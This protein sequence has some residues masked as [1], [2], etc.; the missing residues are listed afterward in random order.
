MSA[1]DNPELIGGQRQLQLQG[2]GPGA[3]YNVA[4]TRP[5]RLVETA[6]HQHM[7]WGSVNG[8]SSPASR[9]TIPVI[10]VSPLI[11]LG[12]PPG[13]IPADSGLQPPPNYCRLN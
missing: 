6:R 3:D 7:N 5:V 11:I 9:R 4:R 10:P 13:P 12:N 1:R 2:I 8:Y